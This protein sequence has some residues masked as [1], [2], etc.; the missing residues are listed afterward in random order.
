MNRSIEPRAACQ[1]KGAS[2]S[3]L[4]LTRSARFN[5]TVHPGTTEREFI[6]IG[7][8][9]MTVTVYALDTL[10]IDT[11][12]LKKFDIPAVDLQALNDSLDAAGAY[13]IDG[14]LGDDVLS[15]HDSIVDYTNKKLYL[16]N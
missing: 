6:G 7:G 14:L 16:R 2:Q 11:L 10:A 12:E 15:P 5:A 4:D 9:S 3:A 8:S 1:V 13:P